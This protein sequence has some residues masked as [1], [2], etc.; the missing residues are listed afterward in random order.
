MAQDTNSTS[1]FPAPYHNSVDENES[2]VVKVD[3]NKG[4]IGSRAS[5]MPKT[6]MTERLGIEHVG[7]TI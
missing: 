7:G 2:Y 5:G 1:K 6:M 3:Q 4:E